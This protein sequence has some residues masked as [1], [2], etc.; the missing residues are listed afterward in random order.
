MLGTF[1]GLGVGPGDPELLTIKARRLLEKVPVVAAP[2]SKGEEGL[3]LSIVRPFLAPGTRVLELDF[4]MT[5]QPEL[6]ELAWEKS[7]ELVLA[8]L[9]QGRDVAF[10]TLGDPSLY[11]TYG[12]L[13]ERLRQKERNLP[14]TTIPGVS[15]FSAAAA[16]TGTALAEGRAG[17]A[18]LSSFDEGEFLRVLEFFDSVVLFKVARHLPRIKELLESKNLADQAILVSRLGLPGEAIYPSLKDWPG[19]KVDYLSTLIIK[20]GSKKDVG[21]V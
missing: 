15:S 1:Y 10:V 4:P 18:I 7:A 8:E 2:R 19:E 6:L 9:R 17:L 5:A 11:S 20:K 3:A 12:Y 13:V 21:T 14:L 16:A